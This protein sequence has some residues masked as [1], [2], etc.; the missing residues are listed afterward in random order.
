MQSKKGRREHSP[1]LSFYRLAPVAV[2]TK[3]RNTQSLLTDDD[4]SNR[5]DSRNSRDDRNTADGSTSHNTC[6]RG[7]R[8]AVSSGDLHAISHV[9]GV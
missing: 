7:G 1:D 5:R 3:N 9:S 6:S 8:I 4:R 2:P